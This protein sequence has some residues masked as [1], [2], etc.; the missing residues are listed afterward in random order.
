[1]L[2]VLGASLVTP[3]T[4]V[5]RARLLCSPKPASPSTSSAAVRPAGFAYFLSSRR[6]IPPLTSC[7]LAAV[8]S[9]CLPHV[10]MRLFCAL[11]PAPAGKAQAFSQQW[12]LRVPRQPPWSPTGVM[13]PVP[14]S[15]LC[16]AAAPSLALSRHQASRRLRPPG[17]SHSLL[18]THCPALGDRL[19]LCQ[20]S[21]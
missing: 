12:G 7:L 14:S 21:S 2:A 9:A 11:A 13:A 17:S 10:I 15:P 16:D 20:R 1:M 6:L 18:L 5:P 19:G 8:P 3:A 4:P